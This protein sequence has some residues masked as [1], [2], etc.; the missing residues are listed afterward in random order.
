[1]ANSQD[2][3]IPQGQR[4]S[5]FLSYMLAFCFGVAAAW[6]DIKFVELALTSM[7]VFA[8]CMFVCFRSPRQSWR[9]ILLI[10]TLVPA[11]EWFAYHFLP[12]KPYL[13]QMYQS[14]IAFVP[15][16]VGGAGGAVGRGVVENL[17]PK[18]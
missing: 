4:D 17:F 18:K 2:A 16:I 6:L 8:G 14:W 11:V 15:G 7:V 13:A 9:W 12:M 1:M 5:E 3:L 10:C